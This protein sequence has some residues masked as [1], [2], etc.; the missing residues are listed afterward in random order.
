[1]ARK[2]APKSEAMTDETEAL[3][4]AAPDV[5]VARFTVVG[6]FWSGGRKHRVGDVLDLT[7][8]EAASLGALVAAAAA[9]EPE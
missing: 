8:S 9:P 5:A 2:P 3:P 6:N 7:P 1:M 4:G